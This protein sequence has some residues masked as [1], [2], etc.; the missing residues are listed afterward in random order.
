ML[1]IL[2][3]LASFQ[4][5]VAQLR[6]DGAVQ[7]VRQGDMALK[8]GDWEKAMFDYTNALMTDPGYAEAFMKR[9]MLYGKMGR[10]KESL[11]DYNRAIALN[12]NSAFLYDQ[13]AK[14]K[15]IALDFP[16]AETDMTKARSIAPSDPNVRES[17]MDG[18]LLMENYQSALKLAD[19]ILTFWGEYDHYVHL[20]RALGFVFSGDPGTALYEVDKALREDPGSAVAYDLKGI[21]LLKMNRNEE[22]IQAFTAAIRLSPAFELAFY[23]RAL[24]HRIMANETAA[25]AD[26]TSALDLATNKA[27]VAFARAQ[28]RKSLGDSEGAMEDSDLA[29]D[30]DPGLK[31]ALFHRSF[32][33]KML[34]DKAGA[35][36]DAD[37]AIN[38]GKPAPE[39]WNH[40]ANLHLLFGDYAK[41][42]EDYSM[43]IEGRPDYT[44]AHY[45][46]GLA[47][48]MNGQT[49][50]G[51]N[52]L[53]KA[54]ELGFSRAE[55]MLGSFCSR[56]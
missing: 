36:N 35:L 44:I 40:R 10:T 6:V 20:K 19:S 32:M 12:P 14:L 46:R 45:N 16:G 47:H 50:S 13:R 18:Y 17:V 38:A 55:E 8:M 23:N 22:A 1:L 9:A 25:E 21:I 30:F 11:D 42:I 39:V 31:E 29:I 3:S 33:K 49:Q 51:C 41:A 24:A 53:R 54:G 7:S 5:V 56:L 48:I 37:R 28:S 26:F 43:A 15:I 27:H 2:A 52:D 34:G 4:D